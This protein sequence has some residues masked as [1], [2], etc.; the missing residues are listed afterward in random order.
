VI[1]NSLGQKIKT[2]IDKT[3]P[4]GHYEITWD[5]KDEFGKNAPSGIY[6]YQMNSESGFTNT[7]KLLL[8][9]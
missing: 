5:G 6:F 8:L 2:L 7:K 4:A 9:K 1:F 3:F